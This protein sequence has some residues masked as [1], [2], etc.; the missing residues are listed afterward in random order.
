MKQK[1]FGILLLGVFIL[2]IA[3]CGVKYPDL[4]DNA[5]AFSMSEFTD[6]S[7]D[8]TEYGTIEYNNRTYMPYGTLKGSIKSQNINECIGYIIADKSSSSVV[9]KNDRDTRVYTLIEDANENYLMIYTREALMN[10][11]DFFRAV[12]TK[13]KK[14]DTPNYI[15]SRNYNYWN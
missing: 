11:P 12:D 7:D 13:G 10:Q 2:G 8:D 4:K 5:I 9:D 3:G 6:E 1:L 14:I 15:D